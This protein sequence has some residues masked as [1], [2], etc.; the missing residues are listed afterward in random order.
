MDER[1]KIQDFKNEGQNMQFVAF[2]N[3]PS[4]SGP[5]VSASL[6]KFTSIWHSVMQCNLTSCCIA[7]VRSVRSRSRHSRRR[8]TVV[9]NCIRSAD[10][11]VGVVESSMK[12]VVRRTF[13]VLIL[14][15][16]NVT[17]QVTQF[18]EILHTVSKWVLDNAV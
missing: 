17:T 7:K 3:D 2:L 4:F 1:T 5:V 11:V 13:S 16:K 15:E 9:E 10:R 18:I 12:I 8:G 14:K 6:Y